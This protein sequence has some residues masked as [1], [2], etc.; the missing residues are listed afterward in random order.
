MPIQY[1]KQKSVFI[2]NGIRVNHTATEKNREQPT[3]TTDA[4]PN[5]SCLEYSD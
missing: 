4:S 2:M 5:S 1:R 3:R